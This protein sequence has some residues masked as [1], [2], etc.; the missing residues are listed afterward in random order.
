[1]LPTHISKLI[2][3]IKFP[4]VYLKLNIRR[5]QF[6]FLFKIQTLSSKFTI[7]LNFVGLFLYITFFLLLYYAWILLSC[8][9]QFYT[10]FYT[11]Y[12]TFY[13]KNKRDKIQVE[14]FKR[15]DKRKFDVYLSKSLNLN[16]R[17]MGVQTMYQ[18]SIRN[19]LVFILYLSYFRH[20]VYCVMCRI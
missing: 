7:N 4:E 3:N 9:L 2:R 11:R 15:A 18:P 16:K 13:S 14:V 20:G 5:F 8:T 17:K 1:M 19:I 6:H 12:L 10:L